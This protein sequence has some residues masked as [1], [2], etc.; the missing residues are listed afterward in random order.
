MT[1]TMDCSLGQR[2]LRQYA[3]V[4]SDKTEGQMSRDSSL[5][6]SGHPKKAARIDKPGVT[7]RDF[8]SPITN[9]A[10]RDLFK[11]VEDCLLTICRDLDRSHLHGDAA[12]TSVLNIDETEFRLFIHQLEDQFCLFIPERDYPQLTHLDAIT[13]YIGVRLENGTKL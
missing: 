7:A 1:G 12:L 4:C 13:A 8:L 2:I 6:N 5:T 11:Q 3:H 10:E 9:Q